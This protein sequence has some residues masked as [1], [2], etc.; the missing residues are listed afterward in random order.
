MT[1]A[2]VHLAYDINYNDS[3]EGKCYAGEGQKFLRA[4]ICPDKARDFVEML[5]PLLAVASAETIVFPKQ[6]GSVVLRDIIGFDL[7]DLPGDT[8]NHALV[9][10]S[11]EAA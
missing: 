7:H 1:I 10:E 3:D 6:P 8:S 9:I 11:A 5:R 2:L 4:F